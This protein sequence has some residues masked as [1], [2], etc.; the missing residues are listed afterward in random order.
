MREVCDEEELCGISAKVKAE[1]PSLCLP[2]AFGVEQ[3]K[4]G[5]HVRVQASK[6]YKEVWRGHTGNFYRAAC[7]S[8]PRSSFPI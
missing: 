8:L 5:S 3:A 7:F 4:K 2:V 1:R 6:A